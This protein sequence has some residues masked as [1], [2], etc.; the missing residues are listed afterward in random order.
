MCYISTIRELVYVH[1][2]ISW[3]T[4]NNEKISVVEFYTVLI[5]CLRDFAMNSFWLKTKPP[6]R[7]CTWRT[8]K[9]FMRL[10]GFYSELFMTINDTYKDNQRYQYNTHVSTEECWLAAW[11]RQQNIRMMMRK[12][13]RNVKTTKLP[14]AHSQPDSNT[15][16]FPISIHISLNHG[17]GSSPWNVDQPQLGGVF[18]NICG[19]SKIYRQFSET[20]WLIHN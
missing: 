3:T 5:T 7:K 18:R 17:R 14:I 19:V 8:W 2:I 12:E 13:K 6:R 4:G 20:L 11:Q 15:N 10:C 16:T 9:I 1:D